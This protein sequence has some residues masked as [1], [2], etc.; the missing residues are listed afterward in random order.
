MVPPTCEVKRMIM[1]DK[2]ASGRTYHFT[3]WNKMKKTN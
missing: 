1:E 3:Q 2:G